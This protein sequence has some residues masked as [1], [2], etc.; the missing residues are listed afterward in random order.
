L[1]PGHSTGVVVLRST[2]HNQRR[3]LI[4]EGEQKLLVKKRG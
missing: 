1:E 3:E 4:L 2:L